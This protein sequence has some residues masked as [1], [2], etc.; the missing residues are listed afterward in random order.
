MDEHNRRLKAVD[1]HV[2]L[3]Y[4]DL[5]VGERIES[6]L[7]S[8]SA[9]ATQWRKLQNVVYTL[10]LFHVK[11][12]AADAIWRTFIE[13]IKS[14][15]ESDECSLIADVKILR[16]KETIKISTKPGFRRMH[17]VIL[18]SGIV[19]RLDCWR[20]E[21]EKMNLKFDS[22]AAFANSN[23]T[24]DQLKAM[25]TNMC[26]KYAARGSKI[27]QMRSKPEANRDK[28]NENMLLRSEMFLLYEELSYA[29]N[30][31]DIGRVETCFL[32]WAFILQACGKHKYAM[33]LRKYLRDIHFRYP[34]RLARAIRMHILV[35]PTGKAGKFR[36]VDW[37]VEH[38][39]LYLKRIYGGKFSNHTKAR[40]LKESPLIG[41]FKNARI[42]VQKMFKMGKLT[43]KHSGANMQ[44]SFSIL[45]AKYIQ[46]QKNQWTYN[47]LR[48]P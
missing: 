35:N 47:T 32:P 16:P 7:R 31:G 9:E 30:E 37:W 21:A 2:L 14:R 24:W 1:N 25:A 48:D 28:V 41:T 3:F 44:R 17:E 13:P 36:G 38:N 8:R 18:H 42:Q 15:N 11:M 29:M 6:L 33:A 46:H 40:I 22:L 43:S 12:A 45:S 26:L 5:G 23:P 10:G 20:L 34:K 27:T 19:S 39:N 4:G